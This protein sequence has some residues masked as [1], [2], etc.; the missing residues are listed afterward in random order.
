[1]NHLIE[2]GQISSQPQNPYFRKIQEKALFLRSLTHDR[3]SEGQVGV[4]SVLCS[5][6]CINE[7][8]GASE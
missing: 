5:K 8:S 7:S 4:R 3:R 2:S 1:M 6:R